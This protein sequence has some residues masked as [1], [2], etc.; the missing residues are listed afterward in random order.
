MITFSLTTDQRER[1][2]DYGRVVNCQVASRHRD[3]PETL[4]IWGYF[5]NSE[6][7][8]W[9]ATHLAHPDDVTWGVSFIQCWIRFQ[10]NEEALQFK[11]TWL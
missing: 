6:L 8:A 10:N 9:F 3:A 4:A 11:L 2:F 5:P 7:E 1:L